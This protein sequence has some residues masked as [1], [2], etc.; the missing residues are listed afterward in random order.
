MKAGRIQFL[1]GNNQINDGFEWAKNQALA[2]AH[3]S[4]PVGP[5]YE[6]ALPRREAFCM[7]DA[8][9]QL[10]GA[11][12]LGLAAQN[13]NMMLRFCQGIAESRDWCSFWEIDRY[14]RPAPVD[15]TS[16]ADFWYN[17]PANFDVLD[18]CRRAYRLTGDDAYVLSQD[19]IRF[20]ERTLNEYVALWDHDGDGIPDRGPGL[21]RRGI[22]S[23]DESGGIE[24]AAVGIDLVAA[25]IIGYRA[26]AEMKRLRGE[27]A[28]DYEEK[29]MRLTEALQRNWWDEKE[30]RFY[31][32]KLQNGSYQ[33]R[34]GCSHSPLYWAVIADPEKNRALLDGVHESS[35]QNVIVEILSHLPE[36]FFK[37]GMPQRGMYWLKRCID[38]ELKRREYPELSYAVVAACVEQLAGLSA[39]A[40]QSSVTIAPRALPDVEWVRLV[41]CPLFGGEID[42]AI[43]ANSIAVQ[44][45]TGKAIRV[46][47]QSVPAGA[48]VVFPSI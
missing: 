4:D 19:F 26:G 18:A 24:N 48:R 12:F 40:A 45:R 46:N 41:N 43:T 11:H 3:D 44:N 47:H 23:Y 2:Y 20:Y 36:I 16:D 15:Y 25:E 13:K 7:R 1:C 6:A 28:T 42:V 27:D 37:H 14:D 30:G 8:S 34:L 33:H 31:G 17:L 38:P 21:A 9:H 29:A 22:P 39:N 10:S 35:R 5:W 32:V